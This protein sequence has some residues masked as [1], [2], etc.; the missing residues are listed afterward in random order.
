M[1]EDLR[2]PRDVGA[3]SAVCDRAEALARAAGWPDA[4]VTRVVVALGETVSNAVEHGSGQEVS[5]VIDAAPAAV[6]VRVADGGGGPP[7]AR[8]TAARLPA[9]PL[10]TGGR[11]LY[12]QSRLADAVAVDGDGAVVLTFRR[13]P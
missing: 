7:A 11:G 12:I 4:D 2:L 10:A 5:V 3:V 9:D 6:T 1:G 13:T 8:L